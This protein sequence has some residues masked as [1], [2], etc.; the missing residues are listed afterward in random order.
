[1]NSAH[2][3]EGVVL[4][5]MDERLVGWIG[6]EVYDAKSEKVG[7]VTDVRYGEYTGQLVWLIV[8]TGLFGWKKVAVPANEVDRKGDRLM[9]RVEK[10]RIKQ[11]PGVDVGKVLGDEVEQKLCT[12]YGLDFVSSP[13]KTEEGC[14]DEEAETAGSGA[15]SAPSSE[16]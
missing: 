10:G 1:M 3:R 2:T 15:G 4:A 9:A 16:S 8:K 6:L 11:A 12:Y 7:T 13:W 14:V 5:E